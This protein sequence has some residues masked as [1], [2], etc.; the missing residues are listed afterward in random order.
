MA[1]GRAQFA[2]HAEGIIKK[3][4]KV[5]HTGERIKHPLGGVPLDLVLLDDKHDTRTALIDLTGL[6]HDAAKKAVEEALTKAFSNTP[7]RIHVA[8]HKTALLSRAKVYSR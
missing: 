1:I 5:G 2:E 7:V 6:S 4:T 8:P 3:L